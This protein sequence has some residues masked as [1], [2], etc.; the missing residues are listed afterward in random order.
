MDKDWFENLTDMRK[1][2]PVYDDQGNIVVDTASD[3]NPDYS[4][5][6]V[7]DLRSMDPVCLIDTVE[8]FDV[9][10]KKVI[11]EISKYKPTP[12]YPPYTIHGWIARDEDGRLYLH[13]K[14]PKRVGI[15]GGWDSTSYM[16]LESDMFPDVTYESN[17]QYV[18]IA[19]T[20]I[21][22]TE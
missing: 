18:S 11:E 15:L 12:C 19:L 20:P 7:I 5:M 1:A 9:R 22:E 10:R 16:E 2:G 17:P 4:S 3:T 13:S 14:K 21:K 8:G 6:T